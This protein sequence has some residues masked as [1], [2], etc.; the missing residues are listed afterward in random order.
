MWYMASKELKS[1]SSCEL[2]N[3]QINELKEIK[4]DLDRLK[5]ELTTAEKNYAQRLSEYE[6]KLEQIYHQTEQI[7]Q[8]QDEKEI[9]LL[10]ATSE[11]LDIK[12]KLEK[13]VISPQEKVILNVGGGYFVTTIATLTKTSEKTITYFKSLFSQQWQLEK[14]PEDGSIFIDRDGVLFGYILQYFRTGQVP[15]D[16]DNA[17]LRRDL[18]TEAEFY[19]IDSLIQLLKTNDIPNEQKLFLNTKILSR[20]YQEQLNK[21]FGNQNQQWQLIYRA[22]RDGFTAKF[23]HQFCDSRCPTMTIIRS[24]NNCIFGGFTKTAWSSSGLEK[25]DP[26]AFLFTLKNV[27]GIPPTKYPIHKQGVQF[28]VCHKLAS[29]PTFGSTQNGG[30]DI[31]I[32]SPFN[33][34][35]SRIGFPQSYKDTTGKGRLT[36]TGDSY[37]YCDDLE[38]FTTV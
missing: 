26:S 20:E 24:Q 9:N 4:V 32:H 11:W 38:I 35:G 12:S 2:F 17:I 1:I 13:S 33:F 15:I 29:G 28:A 27:S 6:I 23:F 36:F 8:E 10:N 14:D 19:K 25:A 7:R 34:D 30:G 18:T 16:V 22:S 31:F 3:T 5:S 37:F 21:L